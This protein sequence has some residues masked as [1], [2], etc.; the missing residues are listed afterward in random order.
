MSII[1]EWNNKW[2]KTIGYKHCWKR[3]KLH[4]VLSRYLNNNNLYV[5]LSDK[6]WELFTDVSYNF[7]MLWENEI[8]ICPDMIEFCDGLLKIL[9]DEW[10]LSMAWN[11]FYKVDIDKVKNEYEYELLDW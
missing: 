5:W 1:S 9:L 7:W 3:Y 8:E 6:N 11:M 2:K 10:V 4:F